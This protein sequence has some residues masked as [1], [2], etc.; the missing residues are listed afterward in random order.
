MEEEGGVHHKVH[1]DGMHLLKAEKKAGRT[2]FKQERRPEKEGSVAQNNP[3]EN[4]NIPQRRKQG[5]KQMK[6]FP[7]AL[8]I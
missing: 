7:K 4:Y 6:K 2:P 1:R 5:G 3:M 8:K